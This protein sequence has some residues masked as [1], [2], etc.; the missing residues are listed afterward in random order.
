ME[1]M[2]GMVWEEKEKRRQE[3]L[4]PPTTSLP[5]TFF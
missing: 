1:G 5:L 4:D 3:L 2:E